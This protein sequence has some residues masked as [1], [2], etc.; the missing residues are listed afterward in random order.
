MGKGSLQAGEGSPPA[1]NLCVALPGIH[2]ASLFSGMRSHLDRI[3][4]WRISA[5]KAGYCVFRLARDLHVTSRQLERYFRVA[6]GCTP[7]IWLDDL[8][9]R[10]AKAPLRHGMMVK[11]VAERLGFKNATHFSRAFRRHE[12]LNPISILSAHHHDRPKSRK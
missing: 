8:R 4:D 11:E 9:A 7:K 6:F 1:S 3:K 2:Q 12:G 5:R 10:D